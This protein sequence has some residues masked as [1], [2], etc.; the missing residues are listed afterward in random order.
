MNVPAPLLPLFDDGFITAVTRPLMS[1]KEASVYLVETHEGQCVA[2][3]YKEANNRSFRQRADYT[4]GRTVRN[5]RQQR[6]MSKGSKYGKSLIEAEWQQAEVSALYRLHAAGVRVP[7]PFHFSDNVLL[8]ELITDEHQQPAPRLWDVTLSASA[9]NTLHLHLVRQCVRILCAGMVHGDLSEY[10]ILMAADGAVIID[11][12]QATDAANNRNSE[13]LFLRDLQNLKN[14]LGRFSPSILKTQYGREIW[15]LYEAGRLEPESKLTGRYNPSTRQADT[16]SVIA[17]IQ[18]AAAEAS[19]Q[20]MS[21]YQLKKLKKA[22]AAKADN[23]RAEQA[24]IERALARAKAGPKSKRQGGEKQGG[25]GRGRG[26]RGR[27]G[28]G[29]RQGGQRQG[30]ERQG[31]QRQGGQRQGGQRQGSEN[32]DAKPQQEGGDGQRKRR[33]RR[34]RR[35]G[36]EGSGGSGTPN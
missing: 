19:E 13:R 29:E 22:E 28:G 36:S 26:G 34:R 31:G 33:R 27:R 30:G 17:E 23:E 4:E 3:V 1:G 24:A 12:P 9:A 21:A 8:M 5:T 6:A 14:Y 10:N 25:E 18:A 11:L 35:S 20:P 2:K 7:T 16:A 15:A 32:M